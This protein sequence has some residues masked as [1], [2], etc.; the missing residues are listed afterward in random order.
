[1]AFLFWKK[2]KRKYQQKRGGAKVF[3]GEDMDRYNAS[4]KLD[5]TA[6]EAVAEVDGQERRTREIEGMVRRF[7]G[8]ASAR[9]L[10][11]EGRVVITDLRTGRMYR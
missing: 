3:Q 8:E 11:I 9:G 6:G 10:K 1:M 4:H 7:Y 5:L 2:G